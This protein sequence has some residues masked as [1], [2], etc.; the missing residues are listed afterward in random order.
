M[1]NMVCHIYVRSAYKQ[2]TFSFFLPLM[3][4]AA[5]LAAREG[6]QL[7]RAVVSS[8]SVDLPSLPQDLQQGSP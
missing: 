1:L 5:H 6:A 2:H 4:N 3:G 8:L 7:A